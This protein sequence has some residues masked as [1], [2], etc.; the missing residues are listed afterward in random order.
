M[1]LVV[2]ETGTCPLANANVKCRVSTNHRPLARLASK[3]FISGKLFI[4]NL[5]IDN[6]PFYFPFWQE[7]L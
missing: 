4:I 5:N 2:L 7:Y 1:L 6:P 3:I